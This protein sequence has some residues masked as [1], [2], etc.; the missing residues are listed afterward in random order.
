[1]T[2]DYTISDLRQQPDF[3]DTVADRIW[4]AWW[5][6]HGVPEAYIVERLRENMQGTDLPIALVAHRGPDFLGTASLLV[7]DLDERPQYT[8]WVAAVWTEPDARKQ[9]IAPALIERACLE[10]FSRGHARVYLCAA[11]PRRA[12]YESIGWTPIEDGVGA[13]KLTVFFR[14]RPEAV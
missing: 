12:W 8:P 3:F 7:S 4:Q 2:S 9:G 6:R 13:L 5:K 14:E 1:M 10:A 11:P